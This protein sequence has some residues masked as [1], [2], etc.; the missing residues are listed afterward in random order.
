MS[1][2][3]R[4]GTSRKK[5]ASAANEASDY[6][7]SD[8]SDFAAPPPKKRARASTTKSKA[9]VA[10][11]D[12]PAAE[13]KALLARILAAPTSFTLPAEEDPHHAL[14]ILAT[15]AKSLESAVVA[16][17]PV[18]KS[19]EQLEVAAEKLRKACRSQIKKQ[20]KVRV[21]PIVFTRTR[22]RRAMLLPGPDNH[23][24]FDVSGKTRARQAQPSGH[25]MALLRTLVSGG[26]LSRQFVA[27]RVLRHVQN[28]AWLDRPNQ[29][30]DEEDPSQ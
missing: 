14:R 18:K 15:Y 23:C 19:P 13:A 12:A 22:A 27:H 8:G 9:T 17:A 4:Q 24:L 11:N 3:E 7:E 16:A 26:L 28:P 1:D 5:R 20:I 25:T 30:E 6:A 21:G 2:D 10:G 29:V